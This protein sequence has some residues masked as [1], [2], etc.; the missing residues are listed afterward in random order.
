MAV[1]KGKSVSFDARVKCFMQNYNIP[2]K[3]DVDKLTAKLERLEKL[4][5]EAAAPKRRAAAA[6][7]AAKSKAA[8]N[9]TQPVV[10]MS[11]IAVAVS[12][13]TH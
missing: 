7:K 4:I 10:R 9:Q 12:K 11:I 13:F 3:K 2:T 5:K 6:R 1:K 8:V